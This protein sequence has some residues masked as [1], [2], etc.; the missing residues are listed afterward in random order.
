[1]LSVRSL[2]KSMSR[3]DALSMLGL[4]G[5][6]GPAEIKKAYRKNAKMFHPDKGGDE[7]TFKLVNHAYNLLT[8][9]QPPSPKLGTRRPNGRGG[10]RVWVRWGSCASTTSSSTTV[11]VSYIRVG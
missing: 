2:R 11:N 8:G 7:K 9:Q 5:T 3:E 6:P 10:L 4:K 1:M